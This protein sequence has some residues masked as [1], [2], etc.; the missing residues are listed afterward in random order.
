MAHVIRGG[1]RVVRSAR[2]TSAAERDLV[3]GLAELARDRAQLR[4]GAAK[5]IGTLALEVASRVVGERISVDSAL[6]ERIVLR[7]LERARADSAVRVLLHPDDHAALATRLGARLPPEIVLVDDATQSRGG[8]LVRGALVTVDARL[9]TAIAAIAQ[10]LGI[11][12]P[13]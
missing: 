10:A 13:T 12:R 7:A 4:E 11:D 8:C 9:E 5:E 1:A 3:A 2:A 6:L